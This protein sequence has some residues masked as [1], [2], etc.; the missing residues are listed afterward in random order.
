MEIQA[1]LMNFFPISVP[2]NNSG[3]AGGTG[4]S[5]NSELTF[6]TFNQ[7][8]DTSNTNEDFNAM[9]GN[10]ILFQANAIQADQT[11][12]PTVFMTPLQVQM[13][14]QLKQKHA[15]LFKK[16]VEQQEELRKISEQLLMTQYGLVPVSVAPLPFTATTPMQVVSQSSS[17][18]VNNSP[19]VF[20]TIENMQGYNSQPNN[21]NLPQSRHLCPP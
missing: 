8:M 11:I 18:S 5:A 16:I 20:G 15:E 3:N 14:Q 4:P 12:R 10:E 2:G 13:H 6:D 7:A 17:A 21:Q 9:S 1:S 19:N